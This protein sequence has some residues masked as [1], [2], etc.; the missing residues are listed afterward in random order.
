MNI[1]EYLDQLLG[2]LGV[3]GAEAKVEETDDYVFVDF[4]VPE[5]DAGKM[6]GAHGETIHAL[7]QIIFLSFTEYL[8]DKK[9]VVN[10]NDYKDKKEEAA[11]EIG[12]EA[13]ERVVDTQ[14]PQHLPKYLLAHQRRVIH[15]EL[16]EYNGV[17]TR[18]EGEGEDRHLVVYPESYREQFAATDG[19]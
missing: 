10:V 19:E 7:R 1:P 16:G 3:E 8:G 13:A 12:F 6:I 18:S 9:V 5:E 2:Y 17:F 4:A 11:R 14:R 15:Q